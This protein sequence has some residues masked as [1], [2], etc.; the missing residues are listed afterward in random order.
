[1]NIYLAQSY[2]DSAYFDLVGVIPTG[3]FGQRF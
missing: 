1:M 2:G 3:L